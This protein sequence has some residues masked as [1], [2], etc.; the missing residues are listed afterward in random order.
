[1]LS[2]N[3]IIKRI[4]LGQIK[5][6]PFNLNH[7]G[8][9]SYDLTLSNKLL[10]Y[11]EDTLDINRENKTKEIIIPDD[12]LVLEPGILYLGSTVEST[13][14]DHYI[15]ILHGRSSIAR[16]GM[17]THLCAGFGDLGWYGTWTLEIQVIHPL[18]VYPN[19]RVCQISFERAFGRHTKYSGKYQ[20]QSKPTASKIWMDKLRFDDNSNV[21]LLIS[22]HLASKIRHLCSK[23]TKLIAHIPWDNRYCVSDMGDV[24]SLAY[25]DEPKKLSHF[26]RK[27]TSYPYVQIIKNKIAVHKLMMASFVGP[28]NITPDEIQIIRHL[29]GDAGDCRLSNLKYSTGKEDAEDASH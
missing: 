18:K 26:F 5:I 23:N 27:G 15:P 12:G 7:I 13:G 24:I 29:N 14:S 20:D 10:V 25:K 28:P 9:N 8:P 17:F 1:M 4:L 11:D 22:D 2:G 6:N 21:P 16:L 19:I 3:E